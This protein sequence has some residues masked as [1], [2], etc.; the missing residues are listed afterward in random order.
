MFFKTFPFLGLAQ[1]KKETNR[2]LHEQPK[3]GKSQGQALKEKR[4]A[5]RYVRS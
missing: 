1:A 5:S 2:Y 3:V 4:Y